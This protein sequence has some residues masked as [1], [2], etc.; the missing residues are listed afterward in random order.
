M[1]LKLK[2]N[3]TEVRERELMTERREF[4]CFRPSLGEFMK[5]EANA[6]C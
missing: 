5:L 1:E 6:H 4:Y 3:K 2:G